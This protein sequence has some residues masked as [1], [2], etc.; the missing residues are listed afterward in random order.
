MERVELTRQGG[1]FGKSLDGGRSLWR[2]HFDLFSWLL[3]DYPTK[4]FF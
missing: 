1:E 2:N 3:P 4:A